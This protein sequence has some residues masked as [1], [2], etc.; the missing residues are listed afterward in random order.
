MTAVARVRKST[1]AE[2]DLAEIWLHIALDDPD[3]ADALL[4]RFESLAKLLASSPAIGRRRP[5]LGRDLRSFP[6]GHYL[7]FYRPSATGI[8][9]VRVVHAARDVPNLFSGVNE[10]RAEHRRVA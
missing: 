8:E 4:D 5:E 9:L 10:P 7:L 6:T 3:A 2:A 1:L